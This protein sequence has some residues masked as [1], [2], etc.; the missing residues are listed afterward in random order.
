MIH[1]RKEGGIAMG[2]RLGHALFEAVATRVTFDA[3]AGCAQNMLNA[4][5]AR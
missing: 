4:S 5:A 3:S 2:E 1:F